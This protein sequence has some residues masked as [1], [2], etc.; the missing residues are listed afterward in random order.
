MSSKIL[1][2][3]GIFFSLNSPDDV[4]IEEKDIAYRKFWLEGDF[5]TA[6]ICYDVDLHVEALPDLIGKEKI[7]DTRESWSMFRQGDDRWMVFNPSHFEEPIRIVRFSEDFSTI[8]LYLNPKFA[9][10]KKGRRVVDNPLHYPVD[11]L[12]LMYIM[13]IHGGILIHGAGA[14]HD[15]GGV[16]FAGQSG[17]GKSTLA[18]QLEKGQGWQIYS[19]DRMILREMDERYDAYGTPWPGEAGHTLNHQVCLNK[20][21]FLHH[22]EKN[23]LESLSPEGAFERLT[24]VTSIPWYDRD[25]MPLVLQHCRNLADTVPSF[26]LYFRPDDTL[27]P[28]LADTFG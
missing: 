28:F 1:A 19:D 12:L 6:G 26:D 4:V 20:L 2:I 21:V 22:G 18:K 5:Q 13:A 11:Q 25:V 9:A 17:A 14:A 10:H 27:L 8:D 15:F 7:F 23:R 16:V 24:H 3:A